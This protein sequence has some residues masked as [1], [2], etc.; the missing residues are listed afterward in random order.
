MIIE[1]QQAF[2]VS[3]QHGFVQKLGIEVFRKIEVL[4]MLSIFSH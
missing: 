3:V 4:K 2:E 1:A